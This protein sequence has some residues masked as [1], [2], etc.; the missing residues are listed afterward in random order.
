MAYDLRDFKAVEEKCISKV[1]DH[2]VV[3]VDVRLISATNRNLQKAIAE[4]LF[5]EDLFFRK[6]RSAMAF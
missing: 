6:S 3:K 5:R 2:K 4:R 1:G